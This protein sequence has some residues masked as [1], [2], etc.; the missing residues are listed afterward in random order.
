[1]SIATIGNIANFHVLFVDGNN[2]PV[3]VVS[4]TIEIF[5][6]NGLPASKEI[7]VAAGTN[8]TAVAGVT[9]QF[10]YSYTIAGDYN[11]NPNLCAHMIG[12]DAFGTKY[13][14]EQEFD[15]FDGSGE[16]IEPPPPDPPQ[17]H[18][19][20]SDGDNGAGGQV[21]ASGLSFTSAYIPTPSGGEGSPFSVGTTGGSIQSRVTRGTTTTITSSGDTTGFGGDSTMTVIVYDADN[22]T[23]LESFTTPSLQGDGA[24]TSISGAIVVT[25]TNYANDS[26]A[27]MKAKASVSIDFD[28]LLSSFVRDGGRIGSVVVTHTVDSVTD[29]TG[30]YTFTLSGFFID[31]QPTTPTISGVTFSENL[32]VVKYLSGVAYYDINSTFTINVIGIDQLNRNTAKSSSNLSITATTS[33]KLPNLNVS[34]F[35]TGSGD[36]TGWNS[37]Q[38]VNGVG[39]TKS[40]WT[41]TQDDY[42][43]LGSEVSSTVTVRDTWSTGT[44]LTTPVQRILVDT[45]GNPSNETSDF[46]DDEDFRMEGDYVTPWN[47]Q[48][49][50]VDGEAMVY[51]SKL[52]MPHTDFSPFLPTT[53][54]PNYTN[55]PSAASYY[56]NFTTPNNTTSYSGFSITIEGT[57]LNSLSQDLANG[58][59]QIFVRR[60][61]STLGDS[62][63]S[64]NPLQVHGQEYNNT[65]FDDGVTNGFIREAVNGNTI[66]CT[67]GGKGMK[68]GTHIEIRITNSSIKLEQF[69]VSF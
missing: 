30:D 7:L 50:L 15:I 58:D 66:Q 42:R 67:F 41:I 61:D 21:S 25:L 3:S 14:V 39:Y 38:N 24:H 9:G 40:D 49:V 12:V 64:A 4:A 32:A 65:L 29:G 34:P 33:M 52:Q 69:L 23:P 37:N 10:V 60:V 31:S 45:F 11:L 19:N 2:D 54:N 59:L 13:L 5:T 20:T 27:F 47:S 68:G 57:Y 36:F 46:F 56:R 63:P 62:T 53:T 51:D 18:W 43:V 44:Q 16:I 26:Q 55:L 8:M 17:S 35:G 6:F 48:K 1:M 28:M 22:T